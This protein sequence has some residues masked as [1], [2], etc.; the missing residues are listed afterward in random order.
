MSMYR[1]HRLQGSKQG[2][3]LLIMAGV[4]G[5]E[6]EPMVAV[7]RLYR[8]L[9]RTAFRGTLTFIRLAN[10]SAF[11][12]AQ[13]TGADELDLARTFPGRSEGSVTERLAAELTDE[14]RGADYFIDLHTG[15]QRLKV[16]PMTGY[17]L[18]DNPQVLEKQRQMARAFNSPIIW[19]TTATLNGRSLSAARDLRVP[20]IYAEH[21]GGGGF[22]ERTV[23]DYM[24]GCRNVMAVLGMI[25]QEPPAGRVRTFV[26]DSRPNS[27]N[28]Q[29]SHPAPAEGLFIPYVQ[30][31]DCAKAGDCLGVVVDLLGEREFAVTAEHSGCVLMLHQFP[32]VERGTGLCVVLETTR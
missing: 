9:E 14:I 20:A 17:T 19:G 12:R 25:D 4:H 22:D 21:G 28:L 3:H 18:H 30:L 31:G 29:I 6:F 27:G 5:D 13:R 24:Q 7:S 16:L 26:E 23:E 8:E 10:E 11:A 15:G 1:R 32:K 2:P